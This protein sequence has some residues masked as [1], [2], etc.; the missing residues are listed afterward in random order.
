MNTYVIN[1]I[2]SSSTPDRIKILK[3]TENRWNREVSIT[4]IDFSF[5]MAQ[6]Y[7]F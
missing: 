4:G 2:Y 3:K 5:F 7:D 6:K 1:D